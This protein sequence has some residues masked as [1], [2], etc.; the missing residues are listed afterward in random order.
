M[1]KRRQVPIL[2]SML[3]LLSTLSGC[4]GGEI[5]TD[6]DKKGIPGG[7]TLACLSDEK[8]TSMIV[9]IDY[10]SG[11]ACLLYTSDA[12]DDC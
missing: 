9:E 8:Y 10:D 3:M 6:G 4:L 1:G 11:Y 12:A 2:L 7:L 5:F